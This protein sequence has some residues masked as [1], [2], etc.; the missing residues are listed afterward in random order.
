MVTAAT[1]L[2]IKWCHRLVYAFSA[3]KE[4]ALVGIRRQGNLT[5]TVA[6]LWAMELTVRKLRVNTEHE[7]LFG[8]LT[9]ENPRADS[10]VT[11]ILTKY[12]RTK[13]YCKNISGLA[14]KA[15]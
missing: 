12:I 2:T 5:Q 14:S 9:Y 6:S 11:R 10:L 4:L 1:S 15:P 3:H 13:Y 7:L 8:V